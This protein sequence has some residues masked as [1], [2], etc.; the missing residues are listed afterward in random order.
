MYTF[1]NNKVFYNTILRGW[2]VVSSHIFLDRKNIMT[3]SSSLHASVLE[4]RY[5]EIDKI[6]YSYQRLVD[7]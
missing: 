4:S 6:W 5:R 3:P 2:E 1:G 7:I